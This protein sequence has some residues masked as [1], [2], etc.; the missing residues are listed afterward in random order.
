MSNAPDVMTGF[1]EAP[2]TQKSTRSLPNSA[3]SSFISPHSIKGWNDLIISTNGH[4]FF[5]TANWA[6]VLCET[7]GYEPYYYIQEFE[8]KLTALIPLIEVNSIITGRRAVCLPFSDYCEPIVAGCFTQ[9]ELFKQLLVLAKEKGWRYIEFRGGFALQGV[10]PY[11]CYYHHVLPLKGGEEY[12]FT[13]LRRNTRENLKKSIQVNLQVYSLTSLNAMTEFYRLQCITR[14]RHGLPP[15]PFKFFKKIHEHIIEKEMG[16]IL[17]ASYNNIIVGGAV[18]FYF[19]N[20]VIHKF[21]ASD[22]K[23]RDLHANTRLAWEIILWS[24]QNGYHELDL[25]RASVDSPGLI[26]YKDGWRAEKKKLNYY[27]YDLKSASFLAAKKD[28]RE[29]GHFIFNRLPVS[30]LKM[31]GSMLYRHYG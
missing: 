10:E 31:T 14:K 4:S 29:S 6:K 20:R 5:H 21:A 12:I 8:N 26:Q 28:T 11:S 19:G 25:G 7:Y 17:L 24:C 1:W 2:S 15:Q 23:F 18:Y 3:K 22:E 27:R 30:L 13:N 16:K 9:S